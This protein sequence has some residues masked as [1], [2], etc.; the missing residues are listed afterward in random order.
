MSGVCLIA[1][2][3]T[4]PETA[5]VLVGNGANQ[6]AI[7]FPALLIKSKQS[8]LNHLPQGSKKRRIP[9]PLPSLLILKK[10]DSLSV[11]FVIGIFYMVFSCLQATLSSVF[12][13]TYHVSGVGVGLIYLPPGLACVISALLTGK[14]QMS[15]EESRISYTVGYMLDRDFRV[16]AKKYGFGIG[17]SDLRKLE[18]FPI[19]EARLRNT[20]VFVLISGMGTIGYGWS[21][22][23]K[24]ASLYA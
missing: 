24:S 21:L 12:A 16:I 15:F 17:N 9:N 3:F 23:R 19:E 13:R 1:V 18:E 2:V 22:Y 10:K 20:F 5:R 8:G 6:K 4:L 14:D 7:F 11:I